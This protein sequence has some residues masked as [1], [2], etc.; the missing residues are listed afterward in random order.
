MIDLADGCGCP[1]NIIFDKTGSAEGAWFLAYRS[2]CL[3][4]N[5]VNGISDAFRMKGGQHEEE[6][7]D[8]NDS[9]RRTRNTPV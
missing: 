1:A 4:D 8:R 3:P 6:Q 5:S 2:G 9:C 7:D